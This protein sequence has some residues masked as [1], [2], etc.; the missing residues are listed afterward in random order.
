MLIPLLIFAGSLALLLIAAQF[1]TGAAERIGLAF[2]LPPFVVGVL[3]VAVGTSLPELVAS[4]LAV[5]AGTSEIVTGNVLGST[6]SNLLL[7]LGMV[8]AL[9]RTSRIDVGEQYILIDLHFML[10]GMVLLSAMMLDGQVDR[11]EGV[12]LL[13]AYGVFVTYLIRDGRTATADADHEKLLA[14]ESGSVWRDAVALVAAGGV[15]FLGGDFTVSALIQLATVLAIS[16]A[17]ASITILSLGTT[18]PELV[19][20]VTAAR[21]GQAQLAVGNILGSC[22]FNMLAVA[23]ASA[24]LGVVAVPADLLRF[25]VPFVAA[26]TLFFYLLLQDKRLSRWEGILLLVMYVFFL[27]TLVR[28]A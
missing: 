8:S 23:G 19:I 20:S 5:R 17:V 21:K 9:S 22:V 10:G 26:V 6:A 14:E 27:L 3:I 16:P 24:S 1:F 13:V 28:R 4:L 18:L 12:L 7:V 15:I 25:A 2:G 11:L